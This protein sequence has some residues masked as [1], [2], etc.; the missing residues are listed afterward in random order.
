[1]ITGQHL[2]GALPTEYLPRLFH[3]RIAEIT[4]PQ[5]PHLHFAT[6]KNSVF[7]QKWKLVKLVG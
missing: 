6:F 1:M 5:N 4:A 7:V 3:E 2:S